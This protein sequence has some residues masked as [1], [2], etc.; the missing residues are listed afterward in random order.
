M[1]FL[2]RIFEIHKRSNILSFQRRFQ[3]YHQTIMRTIKGLSVIIEFYVPDSNQ[4][5]EAQSMVDILMDYIG[6]WDVS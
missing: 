6:F 3:Y 1:P 5:T 4:I 2:A